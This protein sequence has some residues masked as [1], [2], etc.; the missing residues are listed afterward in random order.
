LSIATLGLLWF[1]FVQKKTTRETFEVLKKFDWEAFLFLIGIFIVVGTITKVGWVEK[2]G[3][4]LAGLIGGNVIVGF[5]L[6][7]LV[8]L[9]L[10][11][12]IDNI[13]Y[14][15]VMLPVAD[16]LAKTLSLRPELYMFGLLIG[17]CMGGNITP[18]G[19]SAN[20]VSVGILKREGISLSFFQWLKIGLPFTL[21]TTGGAALFVWLF[22]K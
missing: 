16:R 8:S 13:P 11:G 15:L 7:I 17:S 5:M 3:A 22:W 18:F 10:S 6:I 21:I 9:L 1:R 20:V 2:I 12:F 19:A 4:L 14:I